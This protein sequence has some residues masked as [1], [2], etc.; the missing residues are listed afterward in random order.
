MLDIP[1]GRERHVINMSPEPPLTSSF[2]IPFTLRR[3]HSQPFPL[4][5]S[6]DPTTKC[7]AEKVAHQTSSFIPSFL[8]RGA[9]RATAQALD[10]GPS[11]GLRSVIVQRL[12][13]A[14][15][16]RDFVC[17]SV[18]VKASHEQIFPPDKNTYGSRKFLSPIER[19]E[20]EIYDTRNI[21][22]ST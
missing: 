13:S 21:H 3:L 4:L 6:G 12:H 5:T 14:T 18:S 9:Q 11:V 8:W 22:F 17:E 2:G 16:R 20:D 1:D 10:K 15:L 7:Y 19:V